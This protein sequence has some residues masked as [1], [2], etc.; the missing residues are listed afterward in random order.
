MNNET[1]VLIEK[2]KGYTGMIYFYIEKIFVIR[3][4]FHCFLIKIFNYKLV[5]RIILAKRPE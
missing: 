5:F 2:F 1:S 4:V 3:F